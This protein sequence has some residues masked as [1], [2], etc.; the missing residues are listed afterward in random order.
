MD[1]QRLA[2]RTLLG[3]EHGVPKGVSNTIKPAVA[4]S[5]SE[6]RLGYTFHS[7]EQSPAPRRVMAP[8]IEIDEVLFRQA[9][10]PLKEQNNHSLSDLA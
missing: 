7:M 3:K 10:W 2:S 9:S 8:C 4:L 1:R 5:Q 6:V